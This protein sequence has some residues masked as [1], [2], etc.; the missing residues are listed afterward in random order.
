AT[1]QKVESIMDNIVTSFEKQL[2]SLF[3]AEALDISTD[4]TVLEGMLA[5]EGLTDTKPFSKPV[6]NP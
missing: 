5:R 2:D 3:G 6:D 4:I 1:M